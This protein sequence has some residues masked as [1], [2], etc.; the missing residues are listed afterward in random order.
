MS[1]FGS[2]CTRMVVVEL[3]D[4]AEM[5]M[6]TRHFTREDAGR[7]LTPLCRAAATVVRAADAA[8]DA[9]HPEIWLRG[10]PMWDIA[11]VNAR[12]DARWAEHTDYHS[13]GLDRVLKSLAVE[14]QAALEDDDIELVF[15]RRQ[16]RAR[17]QA[18]VLGC[19]SLR[20]LDAKHFLSTMQTWVIRTARQDWAH[21]SVWRYG[22]RSRTPS[23][24]NTQLVLN[25]LHV[26]GLRARRGPGMQFDADEDV[27]EDEV[28]WNREY[29]AGSV[30]A[31]T[32]L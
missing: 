3:L 31:R 5:G 28:L 32:S 2:A 12:I 18:S 27:R 13:F 6:L 1:N 29:V 22:G 20:V 7:L 21:H 19:H 16:A 17:R 23:A 15:D 25:L 9:G 24:A 10:P 30:S 8:E 11:R 4:L 14:I 26:L